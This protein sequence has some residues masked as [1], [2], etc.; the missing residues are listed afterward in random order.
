[1]IRKPIL[2]SRAPG[3][4]SRTV[5]RGQSTRAYCVKIKYF[6][7]IRFRVSCWP[8]VTWKLLEWR[9]GMVGLGIRA[10][11]FK[12][13]S[14]NVEADGSGIRTIKIAL[15]LVENRSNSRRN[16]ANKIRKWLLPVS[17]DISSSLFPF[18]KS[19]SYYLRVLMTGNSTVPFEWDTKKNTAP[20]SKGNCIFFS[21]P[22]F[23]QTAA[24]KSV[25]S[26]N[27]TLLARSPMRLAY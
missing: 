12:S 11:N 3:R 13:R 22:Q 24:G 9:Q 21:N 2:M 17:V 7:P 5:E 15:I 6:N 8:K 23:N 26:T 19:P 16:N 4:F 14:A 27:L 10:R 18:P 20:C 25:V 1:M